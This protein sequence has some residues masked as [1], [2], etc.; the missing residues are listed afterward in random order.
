MSL[1]M[2][3]ASELVTRADSVRL[4]VSTPD[5]NVESVSYTHLDVYKRQAISFFTLEFSI[6]QI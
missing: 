6:S 4:E 3:V 1:K 5:M 2:S